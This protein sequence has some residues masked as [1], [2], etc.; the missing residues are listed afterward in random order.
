MA[1]QLMANDTVT[2]DG[3]LTNIRQSSRNKY[4]EA[5]GQNPEKPS[6]WFHEI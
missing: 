2:V 6:M 5:I 4:F 3:K 1:T